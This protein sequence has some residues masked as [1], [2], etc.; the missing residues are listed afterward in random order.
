MPTCQFVFPSGQIHLWRMLC[1]EQIP[2]ELARDS[3]SVLDAYETARM[4]RFRFARDRSL[5][6]LS[7]A[8]LRHILSRYTGDVNPSSWRFSHNQHGK[9]RLAMSDASQPLQF[10]LSH[11]HGMIA[12]VLTDQLS[13]GVD[14][15]PLRP[16]T[17]I[18]DLVDLCLSEAEKTDFCK[19]TEERRCDHFIA[20][21]TLKEAYLKACG[22]GLSR[23]MNQLSLI[24]DNKLG[25]ANNDGISV[26]D[27]HSAYAHWRFLQ[28]E[29]GELPFKL[30]V[31]LASDT[32][33][34][35]AELVVHEYAPSC[36]AK[37]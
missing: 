18:E 12:V 2:N 17:A 33:Q 31:A 28:V 15:E 4:A 34:P 5:Y 16:M 19:L 29:L 26:V 11:A 32:P 8:M 3:I 25:L 23:P 21:W 7:H 36:A 27:A 20:M 35:S 10:S 30:S 13:V 22:T 1:P 24:T 6:A 9:P 37:L 14:V